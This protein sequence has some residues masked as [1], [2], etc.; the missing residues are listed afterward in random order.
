MNTHTEMES[1]DRMCA[2]K[3]CRHR[4][5]LKNLTANVRK[6]Y[7]DLGQPLMVIQGYLELLELKKLDNDAESMEQIMAAVSSQLG[8]IQEIQE[9]LK[10]AIKTDK[11]KK[12]GME[13]E[14]RI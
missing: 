13:T 4:M 7:H 5:A 8:A 10:E 11:L 9:R 3:D 2:G 14:K 12:N 6:I 1:G